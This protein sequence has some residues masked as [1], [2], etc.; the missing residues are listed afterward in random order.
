LPD[1]EVPPREPPVPV[2]V[3]HQQEPGPA[4]RPAP[5]HDA[6]GAGL[7]LGAPLPPLHRTAPP[8]VRNAEC[9]MRN[10]SAGFEPRARAWTPAHRFRIPHS[11]LRIV[12][13]E[14]A[15]GEV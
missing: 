11:P 15:E 12:F 2:R 1:L 5:E 3:A 9:G 4:V 14:H 7:P 10:I 8:P 13:L 6:A